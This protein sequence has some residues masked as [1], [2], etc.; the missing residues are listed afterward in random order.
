MNIQ[1]IASASALIKTELAPLA[2]KIGQGAEFTYGLFKRQVYVDAI[3]GLLWIPCSLLV[4]KMWK[5]FW[6]FS[7]K[8]HLTDEYSDMYL[9]PIVLGFIIGSILVIAIF[10]AISDLIG[11]LIN[12]DYQAIK[13][14]IETVKGQAQ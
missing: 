5:K 4:F 1:D 10:M 11:V 2:E 3:T 14:I 13:L 8:R 7:W 9:I 12:P 6:D